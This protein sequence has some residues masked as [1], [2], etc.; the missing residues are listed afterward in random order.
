MDS[1][2]HFTFA[3]IGGLAIG[4]HKKHKVKIIAILAFLAVLIDIDHFLSQSIKVFHNIFV[5]LIPFALFLAFYYYE[6]DRESIKYQSYSLILLV[7]LLGHL[8][9]DT[10]YERGVRLFYPFSAHVF[11]SPE[12]FVNAGGLGHIIAPE[13]I[14]IAVYGL[15]IALA[16]FIEDF[17]YFFEKKHERI[18]SSLKD[19]LRDEF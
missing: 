12:V 13:G 11:K 9:A 14:S 4:L 5:V 10:F 3:F 17:V 15:V 2:F 6:K 1:L 19:S 18:R 7:M 8:I 16:Y